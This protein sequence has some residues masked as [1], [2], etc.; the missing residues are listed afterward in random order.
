MGLHV[1]EVSRIGKRRTHLDQRPFT[2]YPVGITSSL[3][4]LTAALRRGTL[5]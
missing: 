4:G 5:R 1:R 2:S 3:E